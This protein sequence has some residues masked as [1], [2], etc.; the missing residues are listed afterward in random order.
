MAVVANIVGVYGFIGVYEP[1]L[2]YPW[3]YYS[4]YA[5]EPIRYI[6]FLG[7]FRVMLVYCKW[8]VR[9]TVIIKLCL[10]I[11]ACSHFA[12]GIFFIMN[13]TPENIEYT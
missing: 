13:V 11:G 8:S 6:L 9:Q 4:Q 3:V 2:D 10:L 5:L 1:Y 7:Y 12:I